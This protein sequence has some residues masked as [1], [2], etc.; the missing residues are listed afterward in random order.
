MKESLPLP[1]FST[2]FLW[3]VRAI[4]ETS[5][6]QRVPR[7]LVNVLE[8]IRTQV[9]SAKVSRNDDQYVVDLLRDE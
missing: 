2:A 7:R 8:A 5:Q 6:L 9:N 3:R 4:K 1:R